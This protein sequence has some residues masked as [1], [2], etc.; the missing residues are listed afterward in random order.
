MQ[1]R[2]GQGTSQAVDTG[3]FTILAGS[4]HLACNREASAQGDAVPS[5][6]PELTQN[7]P[8]QTVAHLAP[9]LRLPSIPER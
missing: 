6:R 9:V 3:H 5:N 4:E 1:E 8:S 7:A 2:V